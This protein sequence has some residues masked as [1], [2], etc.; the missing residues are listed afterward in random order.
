L[1]I[2]NCSQTRQFS[3]DISNKYL[4]NL[5]IALADK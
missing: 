3:H 1:I 2:Q 5:D 4:I